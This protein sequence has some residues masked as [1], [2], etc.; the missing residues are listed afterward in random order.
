M[1]F[2]FPVNYIDRQERRVVPVSSGR[3]PLRAWRLAEEGDEDVLRADPD[4]LT[5]PVSSL[6]QDVPVFMRRF[7]PGE[8]GQDPGLPIPGEAR[9]QGSGVLRGVLPPGIGPTTAGVCS[10]QTRVFY[11][12][13]AFFRRPGVLARDSVGETAGSCRVVSERIATRVPGRDQPRLRS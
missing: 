8:R 11:L 1:N 6:H 9:G 13:R 10:S 2:F 7:C 5:V 3:R 4:L 12:I